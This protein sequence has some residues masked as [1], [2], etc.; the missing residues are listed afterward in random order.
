[1]TVVGA[2]VLMAALFLW[3]ALL[4]N[5]STP[6]SSDAAGN[7]LA[8][9]YAA[10]FTI[11]IW[12]LLAVLLVMAGVAGKIPAWSAALAFVLVPASGVAAVMAGSLIAELD[13]IG[14][15]AKWLL[16]VPGLLPPLLAFYATWAYLPLLRGSI[17]PGV[18]SALVWG[19]VLIL[20]VI[21]W[22]M[23]KVRAQLTAAQQAEWA[24]RSAEAKARFEELTPD[25]PMRDWA[26]FLDDSQWHVR[27]R[28]HILKMP[29]RTAQ[30]MVMLDRGDFPLKYLL[31]LE[32]DPTPEFCEKLHAY[33]ARREQA[34]RLPV[35]Q[36]KPYTAIAAE[37]DAAINAMS[38]LRDHNRDCRDLGAAYL[39]L[40]NTYK[41]EKGWNEVQLR[42]IKDGER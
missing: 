11:V 18:V 39:D 5:I 37:V 6:N 41:G 33:L 17:S 29:D 30:S 25:S 7:G 34:L 1:M 31:A 42:Q 24:K 2:V 36:S 13:K 19:L 8:S 23:E 9:A 20:S 28:D 4:A 16:V 22:P 15:G 14:A 32:L 10:G 27:A 26:Q 38:W 40:V 35:P 12:I 21:P 3:I